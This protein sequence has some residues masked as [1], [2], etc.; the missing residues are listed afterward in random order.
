MTLAKVGPLEMYYEVHGEG[1]PLVL[2]HGGVTGIL[3]FGPVLAELAQGR[4]VIAVELQGHGSTRDIERP[5]SFEAFADDVAGLLDHLGLA[6]ADVMGYSLGGGTALQFAF[7]H[8]E[9]VNRLVVVAKTMSRDGWFPEVLAAFDAMGPATGEGMKQSPLAGMY[10]H[11]DW[12]VLF[13]KLGELMRKDY[14][15]SAQVAE[16]T[17]PTLLVFAD[18]D[19]VRPEHMVEFWKA[20]GGGLRDAGVSGAERPAAQLAVLPGLTH[21]DIGASPKLAAAVAGF[22]G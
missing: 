10:P 1:E 2:I 16:I 5:F 9:R 7:R 20:L 4:Q 6:R 21:Y 11:I 22:L 17:A 3:T 12:G 14:D 15:W 18:A 13:G 19:S 8:P